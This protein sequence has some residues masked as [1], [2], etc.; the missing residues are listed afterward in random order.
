[1]AVARCR[2]NRDDPHPEQGR[3]NSG[4]D[5]APAYAARQGDTSAA[6]N[7]SKKEAARLQ[8]MIASGCLLACCSHAGL[9]S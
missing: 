7:A 6:D 9:V 1:M 2:E 5:A 8:F 3:K 4:M